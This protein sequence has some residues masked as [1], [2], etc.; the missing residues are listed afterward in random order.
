M[1]EQTVA[2]GPLAVGIRFRPH[3]KLYDFDPGPLILLANDRVL[4]LEAEDATRARTRLLDVLPRLG[5]LTAA[6][7]SQLAQELSRGPAR[8]RSSASSRRP[9]RATWR[10]RTR[11][12][13]ASGST[14][15]RSSSWCASGTC[16]SSS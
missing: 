9:T 13:S 2:T 16:R 1:D 4:A 15:T 6:E 12:S 11:P 8:G 14:T 10:A 7:L 5:G 3:G